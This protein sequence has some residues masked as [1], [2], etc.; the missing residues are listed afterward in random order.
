MPCYEIQRTTVKLEASDRD[1]LRTAL[2]RLVA[3]GVLTSVATRADLLSAYHARARLSLEVNL[4][5]GSL[6]LRGSRY[7][8]R[9]APTVRN[10]IQKAYAGEV[11]RAACTE[12]GFALESTEEP[13]TY[14]TV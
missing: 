13:D 5:A 3:D 4:A 2:S 12:F 7:A 1:L 14:L 8:M 10:A 6:E 11:V 9:D